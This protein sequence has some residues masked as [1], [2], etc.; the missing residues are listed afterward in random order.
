MICDTIANRKRVTLCDAFEKAF[1]FLESVNPGTPD[2][3]YELDGRNV[4]AMVQS[5]E[6]SV[7]DPDRMEMH[8]NYIDIQYT[9]SGTESLAWMS[10]TLGMLPVET[11]Y[12]PEKDAEFLAV[13][14][15]V[16]PS[17]LEMCPGMFAVFFPGD[18]HWGRVIPACGVNHVKKVCVKIAADLL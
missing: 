17:K 1:A 3:T 14:P 7:V 18:A 10:D 5:Y 15:T 2:G 8:R 12:D 13:P 6:T 11:P 16:A 4:Y 9:I